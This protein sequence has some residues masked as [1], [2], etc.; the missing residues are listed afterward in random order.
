MTD[1][2]N[3]PVTCLLIER[4]GVERRIERKLRK[5]RSPGDRLERGQQTTTQASPQVAGKNVHSLDQGV[6]RVQLTKTADLARIVRDKHDLV[7][8]GFT[9]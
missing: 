8:Y 7:L 1:G 3:T 9:V 6:L 5:S 2:P 4:Q